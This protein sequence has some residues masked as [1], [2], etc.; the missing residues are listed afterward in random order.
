MSKILEKNGVENTGLDAA[1][2]N[3]FCASYKD[4]IVKKSFNECAV[5]M[6][7]SNSFQI[8]K[9][10]LLIC[11]FRVLSEAVQFTFNSFPA[12]TMRYHIV[13]QITLDE[14]KQPSFQYLAREV[15]ALRQDDLLSDNVTTGIYQIEMVRF[16]LTAEAI[17]DV[18]R[19]IDVITN[20]NIS[21]GSINI[22]TVTTEKINTDLDAEVDIEERVDETGKRFVDFKFILPIDL[23]NVIDDVANQALE[24][25][26]E[27]A[28]TSPIYVHHITFRGQAKAN[29]GYVANITFV[30]PSRKD[31]FTRVNEYLD[32]VFSKHAATA[33]WLETPAT[34][35]IYN[36]GTFSSTTKIG[37]LLG[38]IHDGQSNW[39]AFRYYNTTSSKVVT[40]DTMPA[41]YVTDDGITYMVAVDD[42]VS[43]MD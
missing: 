13:A 36:S 7:S 33:N 5:S 35:E 30:S 25:V 15:S 10:E 38:F 12:S 22:G 9:G 37:D 29:F 4:G 20:N 26:Q 43:T 39:V 40:T 1:R 24:K 8:D 34:G 3:R 19:T 28:G 17:T 2:F 27:S 42:T 16:T 21:G 32:Y 23:S 6:L 31:K 41:E 11:G 18:N 14:E